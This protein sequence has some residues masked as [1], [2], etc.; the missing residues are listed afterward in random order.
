MFLIEATEH[1]READLLEILPLLDDVATV[2]Q[3]LQVGSRDLH[4]HLLAKG[5]HYLVIELASPEEV[6][7]SEA[8]APGACLVRAA[9]VNLVLIA[10]P[11]S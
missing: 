3:E 4:A 6:D 5:P 1:L 2:R 10:G 11:G 8:V 9:H 7:A